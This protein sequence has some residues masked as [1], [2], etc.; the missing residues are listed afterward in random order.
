MKV[1]EYGVLKVLW[2]KMHQKIFSRKM[3]TVSPP[4]CMFYNSKQGCRNGNHCKFGHSKPSPVGI[5]QGK[6][7]LRPT[8]ASM[9]SK[10]TFKLNENH[11]SNAKL[12][13]FQ[14]QPLPVESLWESSCDATLSNQSGP[15]YADIV[16]SNLVNNENED[17]DH[18]M[19]N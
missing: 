19:E 2:Q 11:A 7:A 18:V 13:K 17:S 9:E 12:Q 3:S 6:S 1:F 5:T 8:V 4:L 16:K 14:H 10:S 15:Q